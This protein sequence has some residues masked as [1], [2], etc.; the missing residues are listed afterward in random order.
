M[1]D[2]H[3]ARHGAVARTIS[4]R[5][6]TD[7]RLSVVASPMNLQPPPLSHEPLLAVSNDFPQTE[8]ELSGGV[9]RYWPTLT[10][11]R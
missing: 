10:T 5:L 9:I 7:L 11:T 3:D 1:L 6:R 8:L 2:R 4:E